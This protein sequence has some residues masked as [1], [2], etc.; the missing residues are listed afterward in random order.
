MRAVGPLADKG[1]VGRNLARGF[2]IENKDDNFEKK[3]F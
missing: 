3:K 1:E 2:P